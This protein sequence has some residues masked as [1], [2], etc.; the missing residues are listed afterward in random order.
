MIRNIQLKL[1]F[2]PKIS[3]GNFVVTSYSLTSYALRA[4]SAFAGEGSG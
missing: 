1:G 3:S 4:S 2:E